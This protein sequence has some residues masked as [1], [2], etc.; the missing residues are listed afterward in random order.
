MFRTISI[1]I[2]LISLALVPNN[3]LQAKY[4][5]D[6][7]TDRDDTDSTSSPPCPLDEGE[8]SA[9][10]LI[11]GSDDFDD[12]LRLEVYKKTAFSIFQPTIFSPSCPTT[13]LA[14]PS[15][16]RFTVLRI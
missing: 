10:N 14:L 16:N 1:C 15:A 12:I 7:A 2:V 8:S 3:H 13:V 4:T 11:F 9:I 5:W 6:L